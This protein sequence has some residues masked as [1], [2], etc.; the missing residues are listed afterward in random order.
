MLKARGWLGKSRA[1]LELDPR[2]PGNLANGLSEI[3][4]SC[5]QAFGRLHAVVDN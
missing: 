1:T 5:F 2:C 4:E 3:E